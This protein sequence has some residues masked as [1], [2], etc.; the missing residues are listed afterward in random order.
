ME[1]TGSLHTSL[2]GTAKALSLVAPDDIALQLIQ[3]ARRA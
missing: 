2:G 1:V 3:P